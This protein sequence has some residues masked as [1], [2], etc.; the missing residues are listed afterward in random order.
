MGA[1]LAHRY[2]LAEKGDFHFP[3]RPFHSSNV[4]LFGYLVLRFHINAFTINMS[5]RCPTS[6]GSPTA[7]TT[8]PLRDAEMPHSLKKITRAIAS[9]SL[10]DV[11]VFV[12]IM[13][14][15]YGLYHCYYQNRAKV[16]K[17]V[18]SVLRP[19]PALALYS[20]FQFPVKGFK[21]VAKPGI[22][23]AN[24]GEKNGY[25]PIGQ[26]VINH[27]DTFVGQFKPFRAVFMPPVNDI[28]KDNISW[29]THI[30]NKGFTIGP[31]C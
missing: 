7:L 29:A 12:F 9:F 21:L 19:F 14:D 4:V 15:I 23:L 20:A 18:I 8:R 11:N 17:H 5:K 13:T 24:P 16:S 10:L 25:S 28:G 30:L 3:V 26:V 6:F 2:L 1:C 31:F 22:E 27:D